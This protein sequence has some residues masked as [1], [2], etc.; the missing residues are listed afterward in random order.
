MA[1]ENE[2]DDNEN[3]IEP[4]N[5]KED[6]GPEIGEEFTPDKNLELFVYDIKKYLGQNISLEDLKKKVLIML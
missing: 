5:E 2:R 3:K 6:S 1:E 4:S